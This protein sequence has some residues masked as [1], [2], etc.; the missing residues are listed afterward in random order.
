MK[1]HVRSATAVGFAAALTLASAAF[2]GPSQFVGEAGDPNNFD[3]V[4]TVSADTKYVNVANGETVKIVNASNGQSF[5]WHFDTPS[6]AK[7]DLGQVA[8]SDALGGRHLDVYV[9][10]PTN[11][12]SG[13]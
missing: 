7:I 10:A 12:N 5:V 4:I 2:A 13:D 8:P 9:S 6:W 1:S 3:R 11:G